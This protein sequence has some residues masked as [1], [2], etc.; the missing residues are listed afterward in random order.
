M[1]KILMGIWIV[2]SLLI[3]LLL[4]KANNGANVTIHHTDEYNNGR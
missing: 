3:M 2:N 4:I 1:G